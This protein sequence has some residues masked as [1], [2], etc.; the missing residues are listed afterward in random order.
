MMLFTYPSSLRV[1]I[2]GTEGQKVQMNITH[3][4]P[5]DQLSMFRFKGYVHSERQTEHQRYA[6]IP[7]GDSENDIAKLGSWYLLRIVSTEQM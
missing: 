6:F 5:E 7:R 3:Y 2:Q 1:H 4:Y